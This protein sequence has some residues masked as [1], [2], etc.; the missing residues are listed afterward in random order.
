[1]LS[2]CYVL[3]PDYGRVL[4]LTTPTVLLNINRPKRPIF[5]LQ[6]TEFH[7]TNRQYVW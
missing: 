6:I 3:A 7:Y 5:R 4:R 2:G 1:M